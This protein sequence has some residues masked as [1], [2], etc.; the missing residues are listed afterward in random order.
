M[1]MIESDIL[2]F[3]YVDSK[4]SERTIKALCYSE[5]PITIG[6]SSASYNDFVVYDRISRKPISEKYV[7]P[8][9]G[10]TFIA[11]EGGFIP[12]CKNCGGVL[13]REN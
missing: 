12:E 10:T 2:G 4:E 3:T 13:R 7:C 11:T 1:M 6:S 8:Y 9:C 5:G